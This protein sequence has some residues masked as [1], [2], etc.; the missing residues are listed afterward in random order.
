MPVEY[1]QQGGPSFTAAFADQAIVMAER[2][3]R[4]VVLTAAM[5]DGTGLTKFQQRLPE[6]CFDV[7]MAEQH[8]VGLAAGL[9]LAGYRP[10]CAIYSTF[11]Q[12][13]YDQ[14]FQE[15]ALQRAPV[16]FCLDRGGLVGADG[17]IVA[18]G[19][20]VYAALEVRRR[21]L[22]S[23]GRTLSVINASRRAWSESARRHP[24]GSLPAAE[25]RGGRRCGARGAPSHYR[26][27]SRLIRLRRGASGLGRSFSLQKCR[28]ALAAR[29]IR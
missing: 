14:I 7:G 12:R 21:V 16:M 18:Y 29:C 8:A 10:I 22:E 28:V 24:Y 15:V 2:D 26:T 17:A 4:V 23:S 20:M 19:P 9:A 27:H 5:L 25:H 13:A 1:P 3:Q 11:L 6:Q